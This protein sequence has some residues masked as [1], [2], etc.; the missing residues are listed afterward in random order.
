MQLLINLRKERNNDYQRRFRKLKVLFQN[1]IVM[2]IKIDLGM[3][4]TSIQPKK[5]F[6]E[7]IKNYKVSKIL[8]NKKQ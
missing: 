3:I 8:I 1:E 2:Q 6:K 5:K 4:F 7:I